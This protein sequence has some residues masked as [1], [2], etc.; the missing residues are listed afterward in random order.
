MVRSTDR[1]RFESPLG[2]VISSMVVGVNVVM[3]LT[4]PTEPVKVTIRVEFAVAV[5]IKKSLELLKGL[6]TSVV[7][8]KS[9]P[10]I[11]PSPVLPTKVV[12]AVAGLILYSMPPLS[13]AKSIPLGD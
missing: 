5:S 1:K 10:S 3:D 13:V 8:L 4:M 2:C 12:S 11:L 7:P 6:P 9:S